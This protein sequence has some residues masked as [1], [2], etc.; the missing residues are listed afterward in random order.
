[1]NLEY[2]IGLARDKQTG[3]QFV[4]QL[5]V[6]GQSSN[7]RQCTTGFQ[8]SKSVV[9]RTGRFSNFLGG[10]GLIALR[11]LAILDTQVHP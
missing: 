3:R 2:F 11:V 5:L 6:V 4:R 9:L 10:S 1:M 8:A 7:L